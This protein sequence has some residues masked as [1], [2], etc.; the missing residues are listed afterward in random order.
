MRHLQW[1]QI[2]LRRVA[3]RRGRPSDLCMTPQI[4]FLSILAHG[5]PECSAGRIDR[6]DTLLAFIGSWCAGPTPLRTTSRRLVCLHTA[7]PN[8]YW[9]HLSWQ[10]SFCAPCLGSRIAL[11]RRGP[12]N[13]PGLIH[14]PESLLRGNI[15][16]AKLRME[17]SAS[18]RTGW[19]AYE[20]DPTKVHTGP[21]WASRRG[22]WVCGFPSVTEGR[23]PHPCAV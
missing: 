22:S 23:E 14:R 21:E 6:P 16:D 2:V 13:G 8:P 12:S 1:A 9:K 18:A 20:A 5:V 4:C 11:A 19:V 17:P 15:H 10:P 7:L 3:S